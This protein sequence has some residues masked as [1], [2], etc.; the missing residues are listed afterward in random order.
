MHSFLNGVGVLI[1][2]VEDQFDMFIILFSYKQV[3]AG[4]ICWLKLWYNY[5]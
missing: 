4:Y 5:Q 2:P 1:H 3:G